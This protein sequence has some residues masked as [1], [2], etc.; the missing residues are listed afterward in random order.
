[1]TN[2]GAKSVRAVVTHP[3]MSDPASTR[4]DESS[5]TEL[6]FSN[7]IPFNKSCKKAHII[8]IADLFAETI[9]R[10]LSGESISEQYLI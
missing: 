2:A 8:S 7:S 10:V 9:R 3:V 6:I 4:V 5:L 1:M